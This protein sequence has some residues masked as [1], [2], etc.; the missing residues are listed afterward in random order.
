MLGLQK[1]SRIKIAEKSINQLK[2]AEVIIL[3]VQK[4]AKLSNI[5]DSLSMSL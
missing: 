1:Q 3:M 2:Y 5:T 4:E